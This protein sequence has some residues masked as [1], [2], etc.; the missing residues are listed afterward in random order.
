MK[1]LTGILS[2]AIL[3]TFLT[4]IVFAQG[5]AEKPGNQAGSQGRM[6]RGRG[7]RS[8]MS[9]PGRAMG[10]GQMGRGARMGRGRMAGRLGILLRLA[11]ELDLSEGQQAELKALS[12]SQKKNAIKMKADREIA[13]VELQEA[14]QQEEPDL[15]VIE[16]QVRHIASLGAEMQF[17]QIKAQIAAKSVLTEEQQAKL[18][19]LIKDRMSAM[20]KARGRGKSDQ[21]G[22]GRNSA[23][24]GRPSRPSSN[25][26]R[27]GRGR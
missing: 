6:M 12:A 27:A 16:D 9:G 24:R 2:I 22:P 25:R 26:S 5:P 15:D 20:R 18:K 11:D 23:G 13:Q 10:Q 7:G 8:Q 21:S 19:E 14:M 1:K 17:S 4:G 3:L